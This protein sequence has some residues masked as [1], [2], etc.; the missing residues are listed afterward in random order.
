MQDGDIEGALRV[1]AP[2]LPRAVRFRVENSLRHFDLAMPLLPIDREMASFRAITGEEEA[3]AAL[4]KALQFRSYPHADRLSVKDHTHKAAVLACALA[5]KANM[6]TGLKNLR[7]MFDLKDPRIDVGIPVS[8]FGVTSPHMKDVVLQPVEP[9]D[10][11]RAAP[12]GEDGTVLSRDFKKLAEGAKFA[13]IREMLRVHSNA[14][15]KLLYASNK[16]LPRSRATAQSIS[17][18]RSNAMLLI[19]IAI[20]ALQTDR[21]QALLCEAIDGLLEVVRRLPLSERSSST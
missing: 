14:R 3:A 13:Q 21:H 16:S 11:V 8:D 6:A 9:L 5:V 1:M 18:R 2:K 20:V 10:I 19:S 7:V 12:P 17:A 4:I 15:N